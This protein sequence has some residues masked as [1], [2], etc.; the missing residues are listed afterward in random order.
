VSTAN[1]ESDREMSLATMIDQF[2]QRRWYDHDIM[3][4]AAKLTST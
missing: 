3:G 1:L 2:R 4:F